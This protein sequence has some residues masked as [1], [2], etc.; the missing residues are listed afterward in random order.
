MSITSVL[1]NLRT[2]LEI[3]AILASGTF[4]YMK[5]VH[6]RLFQP[7]LDIEADGKEISV[8]GKSQVLICVRVKNVGFTRFFIDEQMSVIRV[9]VEEERLNLDFTDAAMWRHIAT[10]PLLRDHEYI[11]PLEVVRE[12]D[13]FCINIEEQNCL[14]FEITVSGV[15]RIWRASIIVTR[16]AII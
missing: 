16:T 10:V 7:K 14:R 4:A 2:I 1:S 6:G 13:L 5:F 15:R 9:F 3:V 11:D 8:T 12:E